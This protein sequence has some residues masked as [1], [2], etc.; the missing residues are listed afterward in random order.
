MRRLPVAT[1]QKK[2]GFSFHIY[3]AI[4]PVFPIIVAD[5]PFMSKTGNTEL[6]ELIQSMTKSEKRH[7]K[8]FA[9]RHVIGT[10]NKY[11]KLFD[12][13]EGQKVYNE[14]EL[15]KNESYIRQ[16]PLLKKRL[17]DSVLRSLDQFHTSTDDEIRKLL[18]QSEI[19]YEKALYGQSSKILRAAK[20][21]C[22]QHELATYELE[23]M[24]WETKIAWAQDNMKGIG[25]I[26][27]EEKRI[28]EVLDNTTKYRTLN[29]KAFSI[30]YEHGVPRTPKLVREIKAI[31]SSPL[32]KNPELARSF[33][34][35]HTYYH[36]FCIYY[37]M[38][39]ENEKAH[40]YGEKKLEMFNSNPEKVKTYTNLYLGDLNDCL[41]SSMNM[42]KYD[43]MDDYIQ[44][45]HD[46]ETIITSERSKSILF[47][48]SYNELNYYNITGQYQKATKRIEHLEKLFPVYGPKITPAKRAVLYTIFAVAYFGNKNYK[49]SIQSLNEIRNQP[50]G[51]VRVDIESFAHLFNI[52]VHYEKGS[53]TAF[54]KS[55]VRS[56]YRYL[57]K[58][59]RLYKMEEC[60]LNFIR[61]KLAKVHTQKELLHSFALLRKEILVLMK[62]PYESSIIQD[63]DF[64]AWLDS[65]INAGK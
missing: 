24:R 4:S 61:K 64:V 36:F 9:S 63:F 52:I 38:R 60:I 14:K 33:E 34:A 23:I 13:M 37:T 27:A 56:T 62:D 43:M 18:H 59:N 42:Q 44:K 20:A 6:F 25:D 46:L 16:L 58:R 5:I 45:L 53:D 12:A 21:L 40:L 55:L 3:P 8:I 17:H 48:Y 19:L 31:L 22:R 10:E 47:F 1:G 39:K 7:F 32:L 35:L 57:R 30:Y 15:L 29:H 65:K 50:L 2:Y 28:L 26:L 11:V 49:K 51:N 41:I 54:L